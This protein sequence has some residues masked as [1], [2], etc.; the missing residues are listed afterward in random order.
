MRRILDNNRG[1]FEM[2][3]DIQLSALLGH[4]GDERSSDTQTCPSQPP[5][6]F[7]ISWDDHIMKIVTS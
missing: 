7:L 3:E 2:S 4:P 1:G 5:H 6:G